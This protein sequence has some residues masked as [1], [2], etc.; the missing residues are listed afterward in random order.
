VGI[1]ISVLTNDSDLG[2][3]MFSITNFTQPLHGFV[4]LNDDHTFNF[5]PSNNYIGT[6]TFSYI[7]CN[8]S[9]CDNATVTIDI[10]EPNT[11]CESVMYYCVPTVTEITICPDFCNMSSSNFIEI[12]EVSSIFGCSIDYLG[13]NCFT[14]IAVPLF[15][16][17]DSLTV[18]AQDEAGNFDTV[19]VIM[20]VDDAC[21]SNAPK[22]NQDN[23][24][25]IQNY[26]ILELRSVVPNPA[27]TFTII[28]FIAQNGK[29]VE[30]KVFSLSGKLMENQKIMP[31]NRGCQLK[32]DVTTYP[33]GT[34]VVQLDN[35]VSTVSTKFVKQ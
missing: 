4:V 33:V 9:G 20:E 17:N 18:T 3:D 12:E 10:L 13:G 1:D 7:I 31:I 28:D 5:I 24:N 14:Y 34:Y 21:E 8:N 26:D 25:T 15:F 32:I 11:E 16:G 22:V 35:K 23:V 27:E 29:E 2:G 19:Q 6:T 30:V